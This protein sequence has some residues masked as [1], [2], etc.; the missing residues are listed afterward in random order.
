MPHIMTVE[1]CTLVGATGVGASNPTLSE[2][3]KYVSTNPDMM[4][5]R[6][7]STALQQNNKSFPSADVAQVA[8]P[9]TARGN[10]GQGNSIV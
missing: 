7:V 3:F 1:C 10:N 4:D 9:N 2:S 6:R 5:T 8:V